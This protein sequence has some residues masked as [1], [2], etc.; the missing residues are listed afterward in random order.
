MKTRVQCAF[1]GHSIIAS[2]YLNKLPACPSCKQKVLDEII[3]SLLRL[4]VGSPL[5]PPVRVNRPRYPQVP[6]SYNLI[7]PAP[8]PSETS[9]AMCRKWEQV[10]YTPGPSYPPLEQESQRFWALGSGLLR[11]P[12]FSWETP[13]Q[14]QQFQAMGMANSQLGLG[15]SLSQQG[16]NILGS[17]LGLGRDVW[18]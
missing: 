3:D 15:S 11:N 7:T 10:N 5:V 6:K 16:N 8:N 9:A 12:L 14:R 18:F 1:C 4:E 2:V 17:G 13:T